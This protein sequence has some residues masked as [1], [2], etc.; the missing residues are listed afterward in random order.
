MANNHLEFNQDDS[1]KYFLFTGE[2]FHRCS[3]QRCPPPGAQ[4]KEEGG[5]SQLINMWPV[6]VEICSCHQSEEAHIWA[7]CLMSKA[8]EEHRSNDPG[9]DLHRTASDPAVTLFI[10]KN[11]KE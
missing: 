10:I 6:G 2:P 5:F 9:S 3:Q 7:A 11:E 1:D 4:G 8:Q